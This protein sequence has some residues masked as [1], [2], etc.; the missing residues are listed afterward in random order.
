M[1]LL[2]GSCRKQAGKPD[3]LF[4]GLD[5]S[6][7]GISFVNQVDYTEAVQYLYL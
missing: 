7:T 3:T 4:T 5:S 1:L 2:N 6:L